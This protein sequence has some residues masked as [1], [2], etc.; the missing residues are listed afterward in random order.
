MRKPP[1]IRDVASAAGVSV[2]VVSRVLNDTGP[3]AAKTRDRVVEA[4][5]K[6]GFHPR[7]AARSLVTG[8]T[9]LGLIVT[10]LE[11]PF[12]ARLADR[13][14]WESRSARIQV[15]LMT[16]H[17][18]THL[19][20][21]TLDRL[22]DRSVAAIIATPTGGNAD[23]WERLIELGI[24]ITFVDRSVPG[25][26][27]DVVRIENVDSA[28]SATEHLLNLGHERISIISGP[29]STTT[30]SERISGYRLALEE[31]GIAYRSELVHAVR[32]RGDA[33]ADAVGSLLSLQSPPTALI[34]ANTAQV[35][36]ALRRLEQ[37]R[38]RIPDQLSVIV[39][40]D[41]PWTDLFTPPLAIVRP[42]IDMLAVHSLELVGGRL[43]GQVGDV[44]RSVAVSAEFVARSS[45]APLQLAFPEQK[46]EE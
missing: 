15:V 26:P 14:V 5:E 38:I 9:T 22:Q 11:N 16:T 19:E 2:A 41:N 45:T 37:S 32:F 31:R 23:K 1:T 46:D 25:V 24:H 4:I 42:P 17:E 44:P 21:E 34:V 33:G 10:D 3:V 30:G 13:I 8:T 40:D 6:L 20:R 18:D 28:R 35:H 12:F 43:R 7:A 39:F 27:I 29:E 36:N